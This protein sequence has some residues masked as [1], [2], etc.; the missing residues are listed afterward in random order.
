MSGHSKWANIKHKKGKMDAVRGKVTTKIS[1]EITIAV[2]M[3]GS[4]P[5]GNMRL[6]LALQKARENNIPKENIQ[7]AIQKGSGTLEGS[8]YEE[9][10]YEGYG[11][12][13]VAII[14]EA[15]TDNRNRTAADVRHL[16]S[17]YG[18]NLG[19]T[20]CVSW[21]F[22]QKGVFAVEQD[23]IE[24]EKLM[25]MVLDAGAEDFEAVDDQFEITTDPEDFEQVQE[26]LDK[27]NIK[28]IVARVTMVPETISSLSGDE[29]VKMM[30]LL[31]ALEDHDDIQEVYTNFDIPEDMEE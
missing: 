14:V 31:E 13:G 11:P 27:N 6:K 29:A 30:K 10:K 5:T 15:M 28:T 4:D 2:R 24:E 1:R 20:G 17:K 12:G 21:M 19:E 22:K 3:G 25:L 16:F 7:R 26:E 23:G 18:G 9:I 8:N